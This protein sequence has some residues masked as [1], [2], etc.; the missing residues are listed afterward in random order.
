MDITT[1]SGTPPQEFD[2]TVNQQ[3]EK[4]PLQNYIEQIDQRIANNINNASIGNAAA[5]SAIGGASPSFWA[6]A[7]RLVNLGTSDVG[8]DADQVRI[9]AD[10]FRAW[11]KQI[12]SGDES[13][14]A[15]AL[16]MPEYFYV[17][18]GQNEKIFPDLLQQIIKIRDSFSQEQL[19]NLALIAFINE[20]DSLLLEANNQTDLPKN[21]GED[22]Y[23]DRRTALEAIFSVKPDQA[24]LSD[25]I[26]YKEAIY[27][28]DD[29]TAME[30]KQS[31]YSSL[32]RNSRSSS[33]V[34]TAR[35]VE[36]IFHVDPAWLAGRLKSECGDKGRFRRGVPKET[37]LHEIATKLTPYHNSL[38]FLKEII[39]A[40]PEMA[41]EIGITKSA[42][43]GV[44]NEG[45]DYLDP[46]TFGVIL[47]IDPALALEYANVGELDLNTLD[48]DWLDSYIENPLGSDVR[49]YEW[50]L[51]NIARLPQ[52][53]M[54]AG[55][56]RD[57]IDLFLNYEPD[58]VDMLIPP[59]LKAARQIDGLKLDNELAQKLLSSKPVMDYPDFLFEWSIENDAPMIYAFAD[60]SPETFKLILP[61]LHNKSDWNMLGSYLA[62]VGNIQDG[63]VQEQLLGMIKE[64]LKSTAVANEVEFDD[65]VDVLMAIN[66]QWTHARDS[67]G[68]MPDRQL[69]GLMPLSAAINASIDTNYRAAQRVFKTYNTLPPD[70]QQYWSDRLKFKYN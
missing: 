4:T 17:A 58:Y 63:D 34:V 26:D 31:A 8:D 40:D 65:D 50:I 43:R 3:R 66:S 37:P 48:A 60:M 55:R 11:F 62:L 7:N 13:A 29:G 16:A 20:H 15:L 10:S 23:D 21:R 46:E 30:Q 54:T 22:G 57:M 38:G 27:Y 59:I 41:T 64:A 9:V 36:E 12:P 68:M 42:L 14:L 1:A 56:A 25:L 51:E 19:R 52:V 61:H 39:V 35:D 70:K 45:I 44:D 67:G 24:F 69:I 53:K 18:E 49:A 28:S 32:G 2:S 6:G 47:Q 5:E 33:I